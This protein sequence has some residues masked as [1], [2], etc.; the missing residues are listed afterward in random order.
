MMMNNIGAKM[1]RLVSRY[2]YVLSTMYGSYF[3]YWHAMMPV[4]YVDQGS[5]YHN[6]TSRDDGCIY[7]VCK[8]MDNF[9]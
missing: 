4:R 2:V 9:M 7:T 6:R 5:N 3:I 8:C 1:K